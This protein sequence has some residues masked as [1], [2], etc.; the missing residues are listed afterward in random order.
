MFM[1]SYCY[2]CSVLYILLSLCCSMY[3]LCLNVYCTVLLPPGVNPI[4]VNKYII[5]R[6]ISYHIRLCHYHISYV[7]HISCQDSLYYFLPSGS[8]LQISPTN[9]LYK[10][11][12][13]LTCVLHAPRSSKFLSLDSPE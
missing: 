10:S 13:S 3:C 12:F 9:I 8:F 7:Y 11:L 5:Y 1:Y 4:A 2:V 6:S